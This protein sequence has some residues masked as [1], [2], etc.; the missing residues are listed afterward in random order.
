MREVLRNIFSAQ[1]SVFGETMLLEQAMSEGGEIT[2][3]RG[4][5][6]PREEEQSVFLVGRSRDGTQFVEESGR[7]ERS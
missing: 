2:R 1:A 4:L 5:S 6:R 7:G 3:G